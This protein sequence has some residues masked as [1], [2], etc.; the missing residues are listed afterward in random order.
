MLVVFEDLHWIDT[1]TQAVLD[2]LV[3][4]LATARCCCWSTTVRN[5]STAGAQ[6]RITVNSGLTRCRLRAPRSCSRPCSGMIPVWNPQITCDRA[7]AGQSLFSG[8]ERPHPGG[9]RG[10]GWGAGRLPSRESLDTW[11]IPVTVQALL[12]ARIDRLPPEDKRLLQTAAVIGT[13]VPW[14]LLQAIADMSEDALSRGLA[15]LQAAEFLYETS[16]FPERAYISS[17]PSPM[18]SPMRACSR[19]G[20]GCCMPASSRSWRSP[21]TV[22]SEQVE[23]RHHAPAGG[24]MDQSPGV[25]SAG[26]RE[27]SDA[28]SLSRSG[29]LEQ[30]LSALPHLPET[31]DRSEQA[32]DLRL[33]LRMALQP[34]N[35]CRRILRC[36][37]EAE[38]LAETLADPRRL[39]QVAGSLQPISAIWACMTRP[40]P[41]PS[42][43]WRSPWLAETSSASV[44]EPLL[45][46]A[47]QAQGDFR[48]IECWEAD[49]GILRRGVALRA[50][51]T[52]QPAG[53]ALPLPTCRVPC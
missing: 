39:G 9:D 40:L 14:P 24:G 3:D 41:P 23:H 21:E 42:A 10:A 28:V 22:W 26:G 20:D 53:R 25:L 29:V 12:A 17:T 5:I 32:I 47:Y 38:A 36:L 35:D 27:G 44:S 52:G 2:L 51:R 50:F 45:G 30:A 8:R 49:R 4:S 15:Q 11:Q 37:R 13:E 1:E 46:A 43:P 18:R 34:S 31:R 48:R 16:L 19:S 33:A 7:D 6:R